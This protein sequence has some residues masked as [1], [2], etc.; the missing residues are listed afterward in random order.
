MRRGVFGVLGIRKGEGWGGGVGQGG[1]V[2]K[3]PGT[4]VDGSC[5]SQEGS[6]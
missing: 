1:S 4:E 6:K 2:Y 5:H 3:Q